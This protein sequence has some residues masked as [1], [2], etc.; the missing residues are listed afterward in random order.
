MFPT[1]KN[2]TIVLNPF[3][4]IMVSVS[5]GE[6]RYGFNG[7]E[8]DSELKGEGNSLD[9]GARIYDSRLG[10]FFS[11]DPRT[12]EY[13]FWSPYS[14]AGNNPIRLTDVDGEGPGDPM[15]H[16]FLTTVAIEIYDA[17]KAKGAS[18]KGA[19]LV[20]AQASLESG[21]GQSAIKYGDFN[22]FGVMGSPSKRKTSHGSVKDYSNAGGYTG[23]LTDYFN[24]IDKTWP[25]FKAV[26]AKK[27]FTSND[28]DKALN[29]GSSYPT[30]AER[31]KGKYAYN[32]D[33]DA[34][35]NNN[36]GT[37]LFKQMNVVKNRLIK[38]IDYQI[39]QNNS[40]IKQIDSNLATVVILTEKGRA[41]LTTQKETLINQNAKL[42]TVKT[43]INA[44]Q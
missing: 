19:L 16:K 9:F 6:Y 7:M 24:K 42:T 44:V 3:G 40:Q 17:A 43:E 5:K 23:A 2:S 4:S 41:D 1:R 12:K 32:A 34:A 36:Y 31:M 39:E 33:L 30:D 27:D 21:W 35:G 28:I 15:H 29:T 37:A 20:L 26:I 10:R 25:D 38:S 13:P 11:I 18:T 8:K 22:L 14:F